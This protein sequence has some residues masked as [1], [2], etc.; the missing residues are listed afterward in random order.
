MDVDAKIWSC[1]DI[2]KVV[3]HEWYMEDIGGGLHM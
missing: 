2:V 3:L 1:L